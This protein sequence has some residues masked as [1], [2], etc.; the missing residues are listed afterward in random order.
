VTGHTPDKAERP[1]PHPFDYV[2]KDQIQ[3]LWGIGFTIVKRSRHPDPFHVTPEMIPQGRAY[4]WWHLVQDKALYE[5][6]G[7]AAVPASRHDGYFMP[8][9]H[10][11]PIEVGGLGLFEKPKFEVDQERAQQVKA[12]Q[13]QVTDWAKQV[14]AEGLSGSFSIDGQTFDVGATPATRRDTKT[15]SIN[16]TVGV[17]ADMFMHMAEVFAERDRLYAELEAAWS[18]TDQVFTSWQLAVYNHYKAALADDP[19]ILKGP[20]LNA[21]LL[22]YAVENVRAKLKEG[23]TDE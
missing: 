15:K 13:Q 12:A 2:T 17:P 21:M 22:P 19:A 23:K 11:G 20:T 9:G 5:H 10:V 1:V 6:S 16:T 14:G 7:W 3:D 8:F 4:Q 18:T